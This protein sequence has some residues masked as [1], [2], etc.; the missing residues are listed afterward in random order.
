MELGAIPLHA[1]EVPGT[2]IE[3]EVPMLA[4]LLLLAALLS[5]V[6]PHAGWYG[7]TAVGGSLLYF[8]ARRAKH[9]WIEMLLPVAALAAVDY[10]LT[11]YVYSYH[12]VWQSY[13]VTWAWYAA[14]LFLG[15]ILLAEKTTVLRLAS[16]VVLGPTSFFLASNYAVWV[17]SHNPG[18][19]Y[20]PTLSG[21]VAC[22]FAGLPFYA[23]DLVS[24]ALVA[25]LAF[26]IPIALRRFQHR[27]ALAVN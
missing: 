15:R 26:G 4:Y 21:L 25:G 8:G 16:A 23:R 11:V 12:F 20:P 10:Y 27:D 3:T 1:A 14:A 2:P 19:M 17:G 22:Y 7:F 24:T 9:L 13:L 5:R 18:G 6:I